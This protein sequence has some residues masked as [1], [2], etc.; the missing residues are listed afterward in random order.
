MAWTKEKAKEYNK[1]YYQEHREEIS[2]RAHEYYLANRKKTLNYQRGYYLA[3]K[4]K[5]KEYNKRY[6]QANKEKCKEDTKRW[7][8]AHKK[9]KAE[10]N[11]RWSVEHPKKRREIIRKQRSKRRS[12][13]FSPLNEPFAG[14]DA[15]HINFNDVIYI[16]KQ[17][18]KNISHNVFTGRNMGV[19]NS[20]AYQFL[21][22]NYIIYGEEG[23]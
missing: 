21:L 4:E 11:K 13:G 1:R 20:L 6:R 5:L 17:V 16:P 7:I 9:R 23:D 15:H 10:S 14:S 3:N 8:N 18:H 19:I 22:G 12:L 2:K